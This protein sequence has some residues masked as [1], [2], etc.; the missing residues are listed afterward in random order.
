MDDNHVPEHIDWEAENNEA[1]KAVLLY[2]IG[3]PKKN[4]L[5]IELLDEGDD[6]RGDEGVLPEHSLTLAD[7]F[8]RTR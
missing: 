3:M 1:S 7:T 4:T 5:P 2:P 6:R 8:E